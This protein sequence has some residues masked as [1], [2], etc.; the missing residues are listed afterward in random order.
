MVNKILDGL[1]M[2]K[3][4]IHTLIGPQG[5]DPE[6]FFRADPKEVFS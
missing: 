2:E 6:E 1:G 4:F 5:I 3:Q